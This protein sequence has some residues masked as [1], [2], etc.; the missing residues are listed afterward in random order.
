MSVIFFIH[1]QCYL[2]LLCILHS[3]R[4]NLV[5]SSTKY[6]PK[7]LKENCFPPAQIPNN[8]CFT[9]PNNECAQPYWDLECLFS[10]EMISFPEDINSQKCLNSALEWGENKGLWNQTC[11]SQSQH[12]SSIVW[13]WLKSFNNDTFTNNKREIISVTKSGK[14]VFFSMD[15]IW[16]LRYLMPSHCFTIDSS[17]L[18]PGCVFPHPCDLFLLSITNSHGPAW[19]PPSYSCTLPT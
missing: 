7:H 19:F 13:L 11:W 4:R 12:H 2:W 1:I 5:S 9:S 8:I 14:T 18:H 3:T 17:W 10:L 6:I 15:G 16:R